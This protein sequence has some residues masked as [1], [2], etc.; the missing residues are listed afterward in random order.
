MYLI[1][2]HVIKRVWNP[3]FP[4]D[5]RNTNTDNRFNSKP[6]GAMASMATPSTQNLIFALSLPSNGS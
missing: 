1:I 5:L 6:Q 4:R 3:L 2:T